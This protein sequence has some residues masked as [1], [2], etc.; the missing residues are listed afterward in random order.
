MRILKPEALYI[1]ITPREW[2]D[3]VEI[4]RYEI[5]F[6]FLKNFGILNLESLQILNVGQDSLILKV[7]G[8]SQ[9]VLESLILSE[10]FSV[11]DYS[12]NPQC[13]SFR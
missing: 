7:Y 11:L 10:K 8:K 3:N 5:E 9:Q 2:I 12:F 6:E 13:L 4:L 1:Q